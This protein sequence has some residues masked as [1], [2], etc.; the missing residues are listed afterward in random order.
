MPKDHIFTMHTGMY[1]VFDGISD[2]AQVLA[3]LFLLRE[4]SV[5]GVVVL[6]VAWVL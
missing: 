4:Q 2:L 5:S 1:F 6:Q 3:S